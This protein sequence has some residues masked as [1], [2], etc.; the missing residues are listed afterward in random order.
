MLLPKV[1][2]YFKMNSA[3]YVNQIAKTPNTPLWQRNY[4]EHVIRNELELNRTRE[5]I[6]NNPLKWQFDR[7]NPDRIPNQQYEKEWQW[8]ES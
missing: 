4:Y 6:I 2:G 1:I 5:Y 7:E 3:K 8:L